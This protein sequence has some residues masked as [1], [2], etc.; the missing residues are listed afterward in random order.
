LQIDNPIKLLSFD[1]KVFDSKIKTTKEEWQVTKLANFF[2]WEFEIYNNGGDDWNDIIAYLLNL[3]SGA[4][5]NF[6]PDSDEADYYPC[7][8]FFEYDPISNLRADKIY[9]KVTRLTKDS[10]IVRTQSLTLTAP[11]NSGISITAG[12]SYNITWSSTYISSNALIKIDLYKNNVFSSTIA[13]TQNSGSYSWNTTGIT[14]F[15]SDYKIKISLV[16]SSISDISD[17][18]FEIKDA[19][20]TIT[21]TL[22]N[23]GEQI[24][25]GDS[26]NITWTSSNISASDNVKIELFKN[27]SFNSTITA[28]TINDGAYSWD[29]TGLTLANDYKI[30]ISWVTDNNINDLSNANFEVKS[31]V[32]LWTPAD[33][34]TALWL[35]SNDLATITKDGSNLVSQWNDK[36]GNGRNAT[37]SGTAR[38]TWN[39]SKMVFN[40]T[41]Y[42]LTPNIFTTASDFSVFIVHKATT[43]DSNGVAVFSLNNGLNGQN[44]Y[45]HAVYRSNITNQY[46]GSVTSNGVEANSTTLHPNISLQTNTDYIMGHGASASTHFISTN[47]TKTSTAR[48]INCQFSNAK[49]VIGGYYDTAYLHIGDISEIIVLS[50]LAD[51]TLRQKAEGYLAWKWDGIN[52]NTKLVD[53]LRSDHPYKSA[54]PTT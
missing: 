3:N 53:D 39:S 52:G 48:S 30:K 9:C 51:D 24:T 46:R 49:G 15:A 8:C 1:N 35:D 36:S 18:A 37:A 42:M 10:Q 17:N 31:A 44:G 40:N 47:G 50:S 11:N 29:T 14:T 23:G 43:I 38:P 33:T 6:Y 32:T 13:T 22:P 26:Y 25:V 5:I 45:F 19:V 28:S 16:N 54:P 4:Y 41:H 20:K 34:T 2:E 21:V 27:G 12:D 7:Y